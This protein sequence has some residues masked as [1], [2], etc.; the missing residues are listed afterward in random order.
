MNGDSTTVMK[1]SDVSHVI[2]G[3]RRTALKLEGGTE[4]KLDEFGP[5]M[6]SVRCVFI[7]SPA[8]SA[9]Y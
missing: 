3:K 4:I 9:K 1:L 8:G 6:Q 7:C 2:R 5:L